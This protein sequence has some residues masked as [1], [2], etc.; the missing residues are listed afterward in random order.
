MKILCPH[1]NSQG[2]VDDRFAGKEAPCPK[3][4]KIF[5][6]KPV[7][8][9][10]LEWFY[11]A[12]KEKK[13][14]FTSEEFNDLVNEGTIGPDHLVWNKRQK[15]WRPLSEVVSAGFFE[16]FECKGLFGRD[17][18]LDHGGLLACEKCKLKLLQRKRSEG[19]TVILAE[20]EDLDY[21]GLGSRVLAK[22]IDLVLMGII[23]VTVDMTGHHFFGAM[24]AESTVSVAFLVTLAV[25]MVLGIFYL[26]W[27]VGRYGATPGKMLCKI[28]IVTPAGGK[29]GYGQAFGR[30]C[31]EFIVV[32]GTLGIGYLM[33]AFDAKRRTLH[34][35][36]SNTRVVTA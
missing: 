16:C 32:M 29:L 8:E 27:F 11:A 22:V 17:A 23:G 5:V 2:K 1:C 20:G 36:I 3:C 24:Y 26:T 31:G 25:N 13:G 12:A 18:L 4:K 34:D 21:A 10:P 9:L 15:A 6:L 30:Y 33:A 35:R 19:E 14:P 28:L 7:Q